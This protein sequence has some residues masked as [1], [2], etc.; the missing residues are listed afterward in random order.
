MEWKKMVKIKAEVEAKW[1]KKTNCAPI[2]YHSYRCLYSCS[3]LATRG[4][5][6]RLRFSICFI[7][8]FFRF[9]FNFLPPLPFFSLAFLHF[10]LNKFSGKKIPNHE[11]FRGELLVRISPLQTA[12]EEIKTETFPKTR[13]GS[14]RK[15]IFKRLINLQ[16]KERIW[17][18]AQANTEQSTLN[19]CFHHSN[20]CNTRFSLRRRTNPWTYFVLMSLF[21]V[22]ALPPN[23]F[24]SSI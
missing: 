23:D 11:M 24:K 4:L 8:F 10:F 17:K 15:S 3:V 7:M 20:A 2:N 1:G 14:G 12:R 16:F 18:R 13:N 19:S 9:S 5:S 6:H 21:V 22:F